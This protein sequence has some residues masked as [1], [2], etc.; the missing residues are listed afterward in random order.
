MGKRGLPIRGVVEENPSSIP[1]F[2]LGRPPSRENQKK[3]SPPKMEKSQSLS[4]E[5]KFTPSIIDKELKIERSRS[6]DLLLQEFPE[7]S[8]G[9]NYVFAKQLG[10]QPEVL[11]ILK[12]GWNPQIFDHAPSKFKNN[13]SA[14]MNDAATSRQVAALLQHNRIEEVTEAECHDINALTMVIKGDKERLCIDTSRVVNKA[15]PSGPFRLRGM[16]TRLNRFKKGIWM[17]K[18]DLKNGYLHIPLAPQFR[19]FVGFSWKGKF[20]RYKWL[21]FG[22]N[23]APRVFQSIVN[24]VCHYLQ[25][26]KGLLVE[27]YLDDFWIEASTFEDCQSAV[28]TTV[29]ILET[30]GFTINQKKSVLTPSQEMEYLGVKFNSKTGICHATQGFNKGVRKSYEKA[31]KS[32]SARDIR[33][34]LGKFAFVSSIDSRIK[35]FL[36]PAYK[37]VGSAEK[38]EKIELSARSIASLRRALGLLRYCHREVEG[39]RFLIFSDAS[40]IGEG[41]VDELGN[42][43]FYDYKGRSKNL[44]VEWELKGVIKAINHASHSSKKIKI[45]SDNQSSVAIINNGSSRNPRFNAWI[46]RLNAFLLEKK[47]SVKAEYNPGIRN[48]L[49]D[50]LSRGQKVTKKEIREYAATYQKIDPP[51]DN[52]TAASLLEDVR[53]SRYNENLTLSRDILRNNDKRFW[54]FLHRKN[55]LML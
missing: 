47:V 52:I 55:L 4:I 2:P 3:G 33:R 1:R 35:P 23:D 36:M 39:P 12:E 28:K 21:P 50:R 49:A 15:L 46:C 24:N 30:L 22:I 17:A 44:A 10:F 40:K 32:R 6:A 43:W 42:S 16:E 29:E 34:C 48:T 53:H 45:Y 11:S 20:Y 14:R 25:K 26:E 13:K 9:M 27:A 19:K 37:N 8:Q 38:N 41:I 54:R 7:Y 18:L 51:G 31:L 5:G